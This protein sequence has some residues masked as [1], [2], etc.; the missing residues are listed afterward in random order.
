MTKVANLKV[1]AKELEKFGLSKKQALIYLSL[2]QRGG[3]KIQEIANLTQIPRSSVYESL[4]VL[5]EMGLVEKV[6]DH[7]SVRIKPY[8][9]G[10]MRHNLNEKLLH[11]QTLM[12]DLDSLE[13]AITS[14]PGASVLP[15]TTIR[16]YQ[17]VSGARQLFWNSLKAKSTVYVYS[18]Y[19]R[20]K[21]VGKKFYMDFVKESSEREIKEKVLINPTDRALNLIKRDTGSPLARTR[22]K[23]L[24]FLSEKNLLIRGE[25]FIY[26][27]VYAQVRLD[28]REINGFE[29]ESPSFTE[30]QRSM[31]KTL[32]NIA[33]PIS[34][35]L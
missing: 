14:L 7:K 6:I 1:I 17:G 9:I 4:K 8:P 20:S 25:T 2:V 26:D 19:G 18:A 12:T 3:L 22:I 21:F 11:L 31:F 24:R 10:S 13:D 29:V 5:L 28:A 32:W 15:S 30:T 23:D 34:S 16:Y 27:N 35:L 33:K